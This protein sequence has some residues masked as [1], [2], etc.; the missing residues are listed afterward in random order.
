[1]DCGDADATNCFACHASIISREVPQVEFKQLAHNIEAKG[2]FGIAKTT[3]DTFN[4]GVN[5]GPRF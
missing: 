1:L 5:I 4:A 3:E 2:R